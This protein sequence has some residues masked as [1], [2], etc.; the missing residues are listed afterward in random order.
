M[1]SDHRAL[2]VVIG[3]RR[4]RRGQ[5][6]GR[7]GHRQQLRQH[8]LDALRH[9]QVVKVGRPAGQI[10]KLRHHQPGAHLTRRLGTVVHAGVL[11]RQR[12]PAVVIS[13]HHQVAP[14]VPRPDTL[15]HRAQVTGIKRH[16]HRAARRHV[17]AGRR[18]VALADVDRRRL[19]I[20][21]RL[22]DG[23]EAPALLAA[24]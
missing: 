7:L 20:V 19:V 22:A 9:V 24:G 21:A 13:G 1:D 5:H 14:W 16:D 4:Y 8:R 18:S 3:W 2:G 6:R 23:V 10:C 17:H 12:R 15:S 11:K